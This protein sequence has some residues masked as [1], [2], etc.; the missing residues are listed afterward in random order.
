MS[1][2]LGTLVSDALSRLTGKKN[3]PMIGL[4]ISSTSIKL[5]ELSEGANHELR[6]E[7]CASEPLPRGAM[8]DG[9]IEN[10]E[11]VA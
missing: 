2:E 8:S 3:M 5:V 9:N 7:R 1:F 6:L 4:D 11:Q 10:I